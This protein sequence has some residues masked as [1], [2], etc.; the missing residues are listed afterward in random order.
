MNCP[1]A[2]AIPV[3]RWLVLF[4]VAFS[5]WELGA[6][7]DI[8]SF[9]F[10]QYWSS[11]RVFLSG[12]NPYDPTVLGIAQAVV[13]GHPPEVVRMWNPPWSLSLL[14]PFG[15]LPFHIS[16]ALLAAFTITVTVFALHLS[17]P[18]ADSL[19]S[20]RALTMLAF[21][22]SM[23]ALKESLGWG[24]ISAWTLLGYLGFECL[25]DQQSKRGRY[26]AGCLLSL[27]S[28]KP[29]LL[30]LLYL[31]LFIDALK[32][33]R[34]E[35][36]AGLATGFVALNLVPILWNYQ[37]YRWYILA[38]Q[39]PPTYWRTSTLAGVLGA[40]A[41]APSAVTCFLPSFIT[42]VV[43]SFGGLLG[44]LDVKKARWLVPLSLISAPYGWSYDQVLL[45]PLAL[46]LIAQSSV[47]LGCL[48]VLANIL[49]WAALTQDK[50]I[51]YPLLLLIL[52]LAIAVPKNNCRE[53]EGI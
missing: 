31:A 18:V 50:L 44:D 40:L 2:R 28:I 20:R 46:G 26:L 23:P 30:Y 22:L 24:Q 53:I 16:V 43:L 17:L 1:I 41:A 7:P 25:Y 38:F 39:D 33:R 14:L 9:D 10:I 47:L 37:L 48:L 34:C 11:A 42:A 12:D 51:W 8:G 49:A 19:F 32:C 13:P 3:L 52:S 29:H 4:L 15:L 5:V 27:T 45:L 21:V 6:G 36:L 35:T